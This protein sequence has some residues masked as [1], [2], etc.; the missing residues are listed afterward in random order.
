[1]HLENYINGNISDPNIYLIPDARRSSASRV[2]LNGPN[3]T[4]K[5]ARIKVTYSK[6]K[7]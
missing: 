7:I 3:N 2:I 1:M 4:I 6:K 5:P